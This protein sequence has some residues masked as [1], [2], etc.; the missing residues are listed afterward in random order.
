ML[1]DSDFDSARL[2]MMV[3]NSAPLLSNVTMFSFSK[4]HSM[5]LL[6]RPLI[7]VRVSTVLWA[8]DWVTLWWLNLSFHSW[9]FLS[10]FVKPAL[11][12]LLVPDIRIYSLKLP[13]VAWG[14]VLFVYFH[15]VLEW[16]LGGVFLKVAISIQIKHYCPSWSL[17]SNYE[18]K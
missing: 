15:L 11:C 14:D 4:E 7:V 12:F 1:S 5:F 16:V 13:L 9:H 2:D 17:T 10:F 8:S 18:Y 3:S 6:L